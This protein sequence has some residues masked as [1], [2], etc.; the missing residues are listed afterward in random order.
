MARD[1][2]KQ[3]GGSEGA[4]A[5]MATFSDMMTLLLTFFI[6]LYSMSTIN[7]EQFDNIRYSMAEILQGESGSTIFSELS[8]EGDSPINDPTPT[9][10]LSKIES[11]ETEET[12][13]ERTDIAE[14]YEEVTDY[15]AS[16]GL[17]GEIGV[18]E[19]EFG[20]FVNIQE[21]V[22]FDSG[23]ADIKQEGQDTL[24]R[25]TGLFAEF[26]ND[27]VVEGHTDNV[28]ISNGQYATNW[29]L[30][31]SRATSV[32]RFLVENAGVAPTRIAAMAYGEYHPIVPNDSEANRQMNRRVELLILVEEESEGGV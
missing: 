26:T 27:I 25:L 16:N 20:V 13:E 9:E 12:A 23:S 1:K 4:P 32:L 17:E 24:A 8:Y 14:L 22:L 6:L 5:W 21:Q 7:Q 30:S 15:L 3:D 10:E 19:G 11:E 29:E 2:K 18:R 31:A 28:P